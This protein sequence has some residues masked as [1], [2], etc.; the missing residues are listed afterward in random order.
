MI[1]WWTAPAFMTCMCVL[2]VLAACSDSTLPYRAMVVFGCLIALVPLAATVWLIFF[3][4]SM[5]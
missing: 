2:I 4:F 1:S 5:F 3:L